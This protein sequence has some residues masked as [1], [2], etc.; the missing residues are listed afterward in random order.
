M[1]R[2]HD[3]Q[4]KEIRLNLEKALQ[5]YG[6]FRAGRPVHWKLRPYLEML[7]EGDHVGAYLIGA[8][9]RR[10]AYRILKG[11]VNGTPLAELGAGKNGGG[12]GEAKT[13]IEDFVDAMLD[14]FLEINRHCPFC[15]AAQGADKSKSGGAPYSLSGKW[16]PHRMLDG[17]E[18]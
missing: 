11:F 10:E 18:S 5:H 9:G 15:D 1:E 12:Q 14:K 7:D 6:D 13:W 3:R 2:I 16:C 4:K 17:E 8:L